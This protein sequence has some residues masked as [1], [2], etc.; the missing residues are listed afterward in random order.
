V[1]FFTQPV[2]RR[3]KAPFLQF[4]SRR[5]DAKQDYAGN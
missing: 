5:V 1:Q 4:M 3:L 2:D